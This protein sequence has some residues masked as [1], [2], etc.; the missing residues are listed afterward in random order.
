MSK[1]QWDEIGKRIGETGV[2]QGVLYPFTSGA[3]AAGVAWS[4]LTSVSENPTGAEANASYAD[5]KKYIE[6]YSEEE[7]AG[8]VGCFTYPDEFKPCIGE[9]ESAPG[10]VITQQK[11][12]TAGF[13]YRTK[14]VNDTD[15]L[16]YGY[17]IH[18]VYGA[19]FGVASREHTTINESPELEELGFDFTTTKVDVTNGKPTA[20]VVIDT[21]K[22]PE[23]SATKLATF[24]KAIYGDTTE[25]ET[26]PRLPTPDEV[27]AMFAGV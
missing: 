5:N 6:L 12:S 19:K 17:K 8:S 11:R 26:T 3:Y 9:V 18:L 7:F 23:G 1:L 16:E 25:P 21:T 13:S 24:L 22:I 10:V 27:V 2:D 4:G 14:V 20:H 15:G